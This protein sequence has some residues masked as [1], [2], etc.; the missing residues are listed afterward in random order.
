M[1]RNGKFRILAAVLLALPAISGVRGADDFELDRSKYISLDEIKPGMDAYAL[2]V[3]A[4]TKIEKFSLK[5]LSVARDNKPGKD[6]IFVVG[7]DERFIHTGA[8]QGC[9][10]SPVYIDGRMAGALAFGWPNTIDPLYGVTPIEEMLRIGYEFDENYQDQ[11]PDKSSSFSIDY[12]KPLNLTELRKSIDNAATPDKRELYSMKPLKTP[13]VTSL[14]S[15]SCDFLSKFS[16]SI[17]MN[18]ITGVTAKSAED[19]TLTPNF[20]PGSIVAV[21]LVEGDIRMSAIGTI[22][23][24]DGDKVYAFGHAFEGMGEV[25]LPM[26]TGYVHMVVASHVSSFK[27]GAAG[28]IIGSLRA[29]ESTGIYGVIGEEAP[30]IPLKI[31]ID[32][33]NDQRTREYNCQVAVDKYYTPMLSG[34]ASA[35][36][37][38]SRGELPNEHTISSKVRIGIEGR[39]DLVIEKTTSQRGISDAAYSIIEP[40]MLLMNNPYE[41]P[42]IT[43]IEV[44]MNMSNE[45][46]TAAIADVIIRDVRLTP[47]DTVRADVIIKSP[48]AQ[49]ISRPLEF[50]L[51]EDIEPGAY[52]LTVAGGPQYRNMMAQYNSHR[53]MPINLD[54]ALRSIRELESMDNYKMYCVL[55]LQ[56]SG[57]SIEN[58][59]LPKL[60]YSKIVPLSTGK[61]STAVQALRHYITKEYDSPKI[62]SNRVGFRIQVKDK[63]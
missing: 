35:G 10:G 52:T 16:E 22:T 20:E 34:S 63:W 30:M 51:P 50:E 2:S 11:S 25:N 13:L 6:A 31:T 12:S 26:S 17:G 27:Y 42:D 4:G 44:Y 3:Y 21:P 29:D 23:E 15:G 37:L 8:V 7:T 32:R 38:M 48:L 9:S 43:G 57:I 59:E 61:R 1:I 5:V 18:V 55:A 53:Y 60:P 49:T 41:R 24:V 47:G 46:T 45:D 62:V 14:P 56:T 36:A 28:Q 19:Y 40:I 39:E 58:S 33:F 54:S